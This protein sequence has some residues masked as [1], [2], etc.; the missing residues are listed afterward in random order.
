MLPRKLK[1][2]NL[3]NDANSYLGIIGELTLPKIVHKFEDW[4]GGGMI[5]PIAYDQGLDKPEFE[6]TLGGHE[7]VAIKQMG[8]TRHDGVLL[9]FLGA[10][11]SDQDGSVIT[12]EAVVRGRH[13]ELDHGKQKPGEDTEQKVKTI[14]S[15]YKLISNGEQLY[16]IDFL[17]SVYIVGGV[18]R[19]AEI[20]AAIGG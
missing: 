2:L 6:W 14:C 4:R 5:G 7:T 9:R 15:Y 1:N 8:I 10:Y 13:Q 16:E 19:Y 12:V 3:F 17:R 18:D 11:Q 20:R